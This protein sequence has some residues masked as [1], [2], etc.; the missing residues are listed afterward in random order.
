MTPAIVSA[1]PK[2]PTPM[3]SMQAQ[4][5][6]KDAQLKALFKITQ[7][8]NANLKRDQLLEL[9]A[10]VLHYVMGIDKMAIYTHYSDWKCT[11]A[12]GVSDEYKSKNIESE[13]EHFPYILPLSKTHHAFEEEFEYVIPT[14]HKEQPVAVTFLGDSDKFEDG[15]LE[16]TLNYVQTISNIVAVAIE[17]KKLSK[18]KVED[19]KR[20]VELE[21]AGQMQTLLIPQT[22]PNDERLEMDARYLPYVDVSGDYYDYIQVNE[23]ECVF[24]IGDISGHGIAAAILMANLQANLRALVS[25]QESLKDFIALFNTKVNEVT[26]GEK[27]MTL[28]LAKYNFVSRELQY[29]NAGHVPPVLLSNG[30]CSLLEKGCTLLGMFEK[31]PKVE[32]GSV[33]L[34]ENAFLFCYTDGLP[35]LENEDNEPVGIPRLQAYVNHYRDLPVQ[36]FNNQLL[37]YLIAYKGRNLFHDDVSFIASRF[38]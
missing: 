31:L 28:F 37:D 27:F 14:Y 34:P 11:F 25:R 8:V 18:R 3:K 2:E 9:Y 26:K 7:S 23:D 15:T 10:D 30:E 13:L 4:L 12:Y 35:E 24:C 21:M 5:D 33:K 6:F 29:V 20:V 38:L 22:M 32:I 19:Q 17:N 16:D 1:P 36:Q